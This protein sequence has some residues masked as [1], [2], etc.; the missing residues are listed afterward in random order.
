VAEEGTQNFP[1]KM[2]KKNQLVPQLWHKVVLYLH[3]KSTDAMLKGY[4]Y[5]LD[6]TPEQYRSLS[7][8]CGNSRFV[9]NHFL[10]RQKEEYA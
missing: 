9:Y 8:A 5:K 10:G 4:R 2:M 7:Q 3:E 1:E 6:P